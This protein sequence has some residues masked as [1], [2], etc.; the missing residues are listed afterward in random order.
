MMNLQLLL[1]SLYRA[2]NSSC[3]PSRMASRFLSHSP[4]SQ[5][6]HA[7]NEIYDVVIVGS[8]MVGSGLA[9]LLSH[10]PLTRDLRVAILDHQPQNLTPPLSLFPDLR[11]STLI[12]S[13]IACLERAG[14]WGQILPHAAPFSQM[15]VWDASGSGCIRWSSGDKEMGCVAENSTIQAALLS[16]VSKAETTS[17]IWPASVIS[18]G[19]P[20]PSPSPSPSSS[21]SS[22]PSTTSEGDDGLAW[23]QLE[24]GRRL[25]SRLIVAADGGNS[26]IRAMAGI[27]FTS[28]DYHQRGLVAT[29]RTKGKLRIII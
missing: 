26:K 22:E 14:A 15:Q 13:S 4:R 24:D 6:P 18:I 9:S 19:L 20:S 28:H 17:M 21:P 2:S 27:T 1:S 8:G 11:V 10:N 12:P 25:R 29:V 3:A 16:S 7:N 23:L 5:E